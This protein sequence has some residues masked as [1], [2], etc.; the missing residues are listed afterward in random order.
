MYGSK[1]ILLH[2]PERDARGDLTLEPPEEGAVA[3]G[4]RRVDVTT[5]DAD[6]SAP[7]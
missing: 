2:L 3:S 7:K 6:P 1:M 4:S 5:V